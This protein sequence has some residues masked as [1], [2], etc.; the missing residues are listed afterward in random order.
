[1]SNLRLWRIENNLPFHSEMSSISLEKNLENWIE[2]DTSLIQ[3]GLLIV[4]RQ[5]RVQNGIIDLLAIDTYSRWHIIEVKREKLDD[6][7]IGQ[8]LRYTAWLERVSAAELKHI[9]E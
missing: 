8:A 1:M 9:I 2:A 6:K 7:T 3:D 4:G 5:L